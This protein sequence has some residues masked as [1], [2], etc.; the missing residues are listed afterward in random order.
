[1]L[2]GSSDDESSFDDQKSYRP[3]QSFLTAALRRPEVTNKKITSFKE[4]VESRTIINGE[5]AD[6]DAIG[7][8]DGDDDDDDVSESAIEDE[9]DSSDWEDDGTE[10]M[11]ASPQD[12]EPVFKRVPSRPNLVSRRSLLTTM[13]HESERAAALAGQA[14]KSQPAM[15][16]LRTSSKSKQSRDESPLDVQ[17]ADIP[18]SQPIVMATPTSQAHN[19]LSPRTTRRNMLATELTE[20]LRKHLLWERQQ[21]STTAQAALK[22]RHTAQGDLAKQESHAQIGQEDESKGKPNISWNFDHGLG[23]YNSRGW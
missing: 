21:K 18:R 14:S 17:G 7:S 13:V 3:S 2:G 11:E 16:K 5:N 15:Q 4:E 20:S 22:R 19:A 6:E 10:S 12:K 23:E 1:M 8:S 9:E